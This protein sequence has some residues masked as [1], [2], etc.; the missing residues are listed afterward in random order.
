[1]PLTR[2]VARDDAE[3]LWQT[4]RDWF[5]KPAGGFGSKATYRGDKLTRRVFDEILAGD[6]VAQRIV[7]PS[8]RVKRVDGSSVE[9]KSDLRAYAYSGKVQLFAARLYRGQTTNFRTPGGGFAAVA[10]VPDAS[11]RTRGESP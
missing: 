9:L 3:A 6:Y 4:R 10:S 8:P 2:R 5:F 11:P 1:V 7:S